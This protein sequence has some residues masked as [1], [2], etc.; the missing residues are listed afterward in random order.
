[1][2]TSSENILPIYHK[3]RMRPVIMHTWTMS[4]ELMVYYIF[5]FGTTTIPYTKLDVAKRIGVSSGGL[6]YRLSNFKAASGS[7]GAEHYGKMT[8]SVLNSYHN[9]AEMELRGM[10]FPELI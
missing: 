7:G 8:Q 1:M 2:H 4:D 9:L 3:E 6:R 5:Q 10:A